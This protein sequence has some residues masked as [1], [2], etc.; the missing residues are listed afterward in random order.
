[1]INKNIGVNTPHESSTNIFTLFASQCQSVWNSDLMCPKNWVWARIFGTLVILP[2]FGCYVSLRWFRWTKNAN[3]WGAKSR[4]HLTQIWW[5]KRP[6]VGHFQR[7]YLKK[8]IFA[9][10]FGVLIDYLNLAN[11]CLLCE[12]NGEK[13][14]IIWVLNEANIQFRFDV[15]K[16]E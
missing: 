2:W 12:R 10:I 8:S 15:I 13:V 14:P 7:P 5:V 6:M 4:E 11:M 3:L 1:M 9:R 16:C